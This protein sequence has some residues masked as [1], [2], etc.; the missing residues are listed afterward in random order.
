MDNQHIK[1]VFSGE[2]FVKGLLELET[3]LEV[4]AALK[5]KNIDMTEAEIIEL[6]D[7]IVRRVEK[8]QN[9]DELSLDQLDEAAG[10]YV[11]VAAFL[12]ASIA[13]TA[14]SAGGIGL[15]VAGGVLG[16]AERL[17]W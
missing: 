12:V 17:R 16:I 13:A 10:G 15:I 5:G 6:R 1:E 14:I 3:P 11:G 4:Q 9:G 2:A 8:A 7:E